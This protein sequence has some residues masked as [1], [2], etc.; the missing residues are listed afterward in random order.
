MSKPSSDI[1]SD[2]MDLYF[3]REVMAMTET[4]RREIPSNML[5]K[6]FDQR[7]QFKHAGASK[8]SFVDKLMILQRGLRKSVFIVIEDEFGES[9]QEFLQLRKE[10]RTRKFN[11]EQIEHMNGTFVPGGYELINTLALMSDVSRS[12]MYNYLNKIKNIPR[13]RVDEWVDQMVYITKFIVRFEGNK[14]KWMA[15]T[16][17]NIQ[18]FLILISL[19]DGE[20][21]PSVNMVRETYKNSLYMGSTRMKSAFGTLQTKKLVVKYG[22]SKG[23]KMRITPTGK[24]IINR[25]MLKII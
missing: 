23:A 11:P 22:V 15:E 5:F 8:L 19:Y 12:P 24:D 20:T 9:V 18:E 14:K 25:V 21:V 13:N 3:A 7:G 16:G 4:Q 1:Q 17:L 6:I 2:N 10:L